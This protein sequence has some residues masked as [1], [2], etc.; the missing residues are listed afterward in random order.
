MLK[1]HNIHI[2]CLKQYGGMVVTPTILMV[3]KEIQVSICRIVDYHSN[4]TQGHS[5]KIYV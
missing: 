2:N 4:E 3:F 5:S 1:H